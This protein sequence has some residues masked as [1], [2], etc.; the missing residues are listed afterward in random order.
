MRGKPEF[1]AKVLA[2]PK[3]LASDRADVYEDLFIIDGGD[4][5]LRTLN[6]DLDTVS[7]VFDRIDAPTFECKKRS[8][9]WCSGRS[10]RPQSG[11][12]RDPAGSAVPS[13]RLPSQST[14]ASATGRVTRMRCRSTHFQS[15]VRGDTSF[16]RAMS[17]DVPALGLMSVKVRAEKSMDVRVRGRNVRGGT[18]LKPLFAANRRESL[19][20]PGWTSYPR[21]HSQMGM[22]WTHAPAVFRNLGESGT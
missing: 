3:L 22:F 13:H 19:R 15:N 7:L 14:S 2:T 20:L 5:R 12:Y 18:R 10:T 1:L 17:A 6:D 16:S 21:G 8:G 4:P 11:G 9:A